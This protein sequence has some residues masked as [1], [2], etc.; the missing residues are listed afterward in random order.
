MEPL[1]FALGEGLIRDV[2]EHVAVEPPDARL[3]RIADQQLLLLG[4][5]ERVGVER[6]HHRK[7]VLVEASARED[8]R[9]PDEGPRRTGQLVDPRRD[10][11]LDGRREQ[12]GRRGG[13]ARWEVPLFS[14]HHPGDLDDEER[15]AARMARHAL[16]GVTLK[17]AGL[18]REPYTVFL[19]EPLDPERGRIADAAGPVGPVRQEVP[20][21][22]A[23]HHQGNAPSLL[24]QLFDQIEQQRI[25]L[26]EILE[27]HHDG[28]GGGDRGEPREDAAAHLGDV[29]AVLLV[30]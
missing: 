7:L 8:R 10:H 25:G 29:V 5:G 23:D 14:G 2:A 6:D 3:R 30:P 9:P 11:R 27:D 18:H 16:G 19:G 1:T 26:L 24:H 12:R 22:D 20:P 13:A 28:P 4:F 21:G 15:V 17:S